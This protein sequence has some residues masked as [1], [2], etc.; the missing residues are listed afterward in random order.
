MENK[1]LTHTSGARGLPSRLQ[2]RG[3]CPLRSACFVVLCGA[4][5]RGSEV[6][7]Q[8]PPTRGVGVAFVGLR[9]RPALSWS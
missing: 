4:E 6:G 1:K 2:Q 7:G 9:A 3:L 8:N 5:P